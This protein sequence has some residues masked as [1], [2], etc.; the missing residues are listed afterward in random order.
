MPV[1]DTVI[2]LRGDGRCGVRA[3]QAHAPTK[4]AVPRGGDVGFAGGGDC[5]RTTGFDVIRRFRTPSRLSARAAAAAGRPQGIAPTSGL[6]QRG[7][8]PSHWASR[9]VQRGKISESGRFRRALRGHG[10]ESGMN[11]LINAATQRKLR[12]TPRPDS[13]DI[14]YRKTRPWIH[15]SILGR[16]S[17]TFR[18]RWASGGVASLE[19]SRQPAAS[20]AA[21]TRR[22]GGSGSAM[23]NA[24][25][26]ARRS[27]TSAPVAF[28][29]GVGPRSVITDHD[30]QPARSV[31][32]ALAAF[33]RSPFAVRRSPFAVRH[34]ERVSDDT[35]PIPGSPSEPVRRPG[36]SVQPG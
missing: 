17:V 24:D 23:G 33:R 4:S 22:L 18:A 19:S 15:R 16:A 36:R 11:P 25:L 14:R 7:E 27:F 12:S 3:G 29:G 34:H 2:A 20:T 31:R 32:P 30:P 8:C 35:V 9:P 6:R 26:G 10:A 13:S 1:A 28:R 5:S 21:P